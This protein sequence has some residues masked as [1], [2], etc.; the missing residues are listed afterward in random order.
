M[1]LAVAALDLTLSGSVLYVCLPPELGVSFGHFL[2]IYLL[3][4][5]AA[6]LSHVPGGLGVLEL[7]IIVLLR[8]RASGTSHRF[9][10]L[11]FVRSTI[12]CHWQ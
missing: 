4:L 11:R 8:P 6:V 3:A 7:I 10:A 9:V 12:C 1:Q 5:V 2:A